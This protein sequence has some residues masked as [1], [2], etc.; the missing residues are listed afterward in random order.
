MPDGGHAEVVAEG[1]GAVLERLLWGWQMLWYAFWRPGIG[2]QAV[3][4]VWRDC[5]APEV[6][7]RW[8]RFV[9]L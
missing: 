2:T 6:G 9:R 8:C 5:C 1:E 4:G 7:V 3:K